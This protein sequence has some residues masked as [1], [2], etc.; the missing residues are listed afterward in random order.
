MGAK[1]RARNPA[2]LYIRGADSR[3][4]EDEFLRTVWMRLWQYGHFVGLGADVGDAFRYANQ[5]AV[6]KHRNSDNYK[7]MFKT[8]GDEGL[9]EGEPV[10]T[11]STFVYAFRR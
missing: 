10:M 11:T 9:I 2:V 3:R 4:S 1:E 7:N 6:E 8:M 5:E